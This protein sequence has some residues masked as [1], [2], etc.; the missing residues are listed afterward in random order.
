MAGLRL[1]RSI[2]PLRNACFAL[3]LTLLAV[4]LMLAPSSASASPSVGSGPR[5]VFLL[6]TPGLPFERLMAVPGFRKLARVGG[7]GLMTTRSGPGGQPLAGLQTLFNGSTSYR[8]E[9]QPSLLDRALTAAGVA[10]CS[11][12]P[13]FVPRC[14]HAYRRTL[15]VQR[16]AGRAGEWVA[17][18]E[19]LLPRIDPYPSLIL[20]LAPSVSGPMK[21]RGDE[22][23]PMFMARTV[24]AQRFPANGPLHTVTSDSTRLSGVVSNVDVAPTILRFFGVPIPTQ[25]EG[26]P[27]RTINEPPPFDLNR[28]HL[29][30]RRT[31][32]PV[33]LGEVAFISLAGL[34]II[35]ALVL[36]GRRGRL[37]LRFAGAVQLLL[38][39]SAAFPLVIMAGGLLP[40]FTYAWV[41]PWLVA[42]TVGLA[43]AAERS[44][45]RP[46]LGPLRFLAALSVAFVVVDLALFGGHAFRFPLE[47]GTALDGVRFYGM[48]NFAISPLLAS[49]L[50]LTWSLDAVAGTVLLAALGMV[51][52]F[53]QLGANV[54][55]AIALFSA[56]GMWPVLRGH[57]LE[58]RRLIVAAVVGLGAAV[59]GT[60][61]VLWANRVLAVTPT[62]ATRFAGSSGGS[63]MS[64]VLHRLR[65][66]VTEV[67][68]FPAILIPLV[69]LAVLAAL[70]L[71]EVK[72][73]RPIVTGIPEWR[74]MLFVLIAAAAVAFVANDTG[75]TA[76]A[77]AFD[78]AMV[79]IAYPVMLAARGRRP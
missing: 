51:A 48:P 34:P 11:L 58:L 64:D 33:Q 38:M 70:L 41:V 29:E 13:N 73:I 39:A 36:M 28:R 53:P 37:G 18:L 12:G 42:G 50:I 32:L 40:H 69:G 63:Q 23:T 17:T 14:P 77:P 59:A 72:P 47:G 66:D 16:V 71:A 22:V 74:T 57:D 5:Y 6:L 49:G 75:S 7:A 2:R 46:P 76:A 67:A 8:P 26:Q 78:Y 35:A 24:G 44:K 15:Y 30:Y 56:S 62:H 3:G 55:A 19:R 43:F 45:L 10:Q 52:G 4:P 27:I 79:G 25:M 68:R 54:G 65:L 1:S 21:A 60:G 9:T 61:V 31:Y 20:V